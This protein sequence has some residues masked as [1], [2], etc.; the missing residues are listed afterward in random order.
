MNLTGSVLLTIKFAGLGS[1]VRAKNCDL[2]FE[3]V[4]LGLGQH[5]QDLGQSF[6]YD[7]DMPADK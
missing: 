5:F 7:S 4:P 3:N 6:F 2:G 1:L